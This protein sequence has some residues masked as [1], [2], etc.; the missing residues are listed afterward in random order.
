MHDDHFL[1]IEPAASWADGKNFN[2]WL[3][4][5]GN[6]REHPEPISFF[7]LGHL[8]LF[9][10]VFQFINMEHPGHQMLLIRILHALYSVL[11]V[12]LV[13]RITQKLSDKRNAIT[14]GWLMAAIAILPNFSVRNLV[15][16]VCM[17][18]LLAGIYWIVKNYDVKE[19]SR[20][21]VRIHS[22]IILGAGFIMGLAVGIRYQT[23]IFVAVTGVM[24]AYHSGIKNFMLFGITSA[25]AFS[26]TQAD[27][28]MLW[29][30]QPFQHLLGYF[31]YNQQNAMNY[32]GSDL[33]YLSFISIFILPPV[34]LL[35][36]FGFFRSYKKYALI[37]FPTISF[38]IFH[39]IFPNKQERFI[40]PALPFFVI[41]GTIGWKEFLEEKITSSVWHKINSYSWKFFWVFNLAAMIVFSFTYSKKSRVEAMI[42]LYERGNCDNFVLEYTHK[43]K[44]AMLPEFYTGI[45]D[46]YYY[47]NNTTETTSII[48]NFKEV[49]DVQKGSVHEMDT[50]NYYVFYDSEKLDERVKKIKDIFPSLTHCAHIEAGWFDKML[51]RLNPLNGLEEFYIYEV[52]DKADLDATRYTARLDDTPH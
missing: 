1:T 4:G 38:L 32:P 21:T 29:G 19:L 25:A 13:Y 2:D 20:S 3:P 9:F 17:P 31:Q 16:M 40:L 51:H 14:A 30:G 48:K 5:I 47:W 35:L 6:E 8:Y 22:G 27:D 11:S 28:I 36:L 41:L 39:I 23:G 52:T 12:Y 15:E 10:K 46:N 45:W 37:F 42:F 50:P 18:P 7:Y 24:I 43:E 26:F 34:S 44:A 49:E 33:A